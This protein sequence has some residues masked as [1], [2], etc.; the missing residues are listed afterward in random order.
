YG[1]DV[2]KYKSNWWN[3]EMSNLILPT[4]KS[5]AALLTSSTGKD[6]SRLV[7]AKLFREMKLQGAKTAAAYTSE[8]QV[9]PLIFD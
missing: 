6:L 7:G 5:N 2:S 9:K 8:M 1:D 3:P 4:Q